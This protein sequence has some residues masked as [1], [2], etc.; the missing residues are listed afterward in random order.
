MSVLAL[1]FIMKTDEIRHTVVKYW[2]FCYSLEVRNI[3][4]HVRVNDLLL[5]ILGTVCSYYGIWHIRVQILL[6]NFFHAHAGIPL[7]VAT[8]VNWDVA[9]CRTLAQVGT[10]LVHIK[11]SSD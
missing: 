4:L 1:C 7:E 2:I 9:T 8:L 3:S 11:H 5:E 10:T 6:G